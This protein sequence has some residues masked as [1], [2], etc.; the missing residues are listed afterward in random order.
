VSNTLT[1]AE[2]RRAKFPKGSRVRLVRFGGDD[3][4]RE[5]LPEGSC[6]EVQFVDSL[7]TVHVLWDDGRRLGAATEDEIELV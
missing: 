4:W 2:Q 5:T 7:G 3:G 1:K 6:G